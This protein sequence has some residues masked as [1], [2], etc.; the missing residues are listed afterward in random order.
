MKEIKFTIYNGDT[1]VVLEVTQDKLEAILEKIIDFAKQNNQVSGEGIAQND[2]C[3]IYA[4]SLLGDIWD[5]ILKPT[6]KEL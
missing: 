3:N 6:T 5:D 2:D 4:S 1:E